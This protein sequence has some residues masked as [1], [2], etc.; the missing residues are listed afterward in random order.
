M[1]SEKKAMLHD[2]GDGVLVGVSPTGHA[3]TIETDGKRNRAP[4]P[5]ELLLLGVGGC[6]AADVIS[7]LGKMREQ[8]TAYRVEIR[9]ERREEHPRSY[10]RIEIRHI[11]TGRNL[12]EKN[13]AHAIELS[14]TKYCG[15]SASLR[16]TA[17]IVT[18]YEIVED[19]GT[20]GS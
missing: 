3:I 20:A 19:P 8:V 6:T 15:A 18:S 16:P 4:S 5:M 10:K 2:A 1:L 14:D 17:E 11:L 12:S 9:S 13:V 7:I